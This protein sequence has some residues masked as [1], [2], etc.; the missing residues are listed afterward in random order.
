[1]FG[2]FPLF[3][4]SLHKLDRNCVQLIVLVAVGAAPLWGVRPVRVIM[5]VV[6][7]SRVYTD[8]AISAVVR[9]HFITIYPIR[10][11][12]CYSYCCYCCFVEPFP[13]FVCIRYE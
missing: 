9:V 3:I 1:M 7:F 4:R 2:L 5:L 6:W 10:R 8:V 13:Y 12:G 11:A